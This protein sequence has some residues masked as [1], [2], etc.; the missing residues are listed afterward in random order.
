M[1]NCPARAGTV[2]HPVGS[3]RMVPDPASDAVDARLK[4]YGL[5]W[6]RAVDAAIV[7]TLTS[8]DIN[9]PAI[10][11]AEKAAGRS[12]QMRHLRPYPNVHGALHRCTI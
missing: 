12:W 11:V 10:M 4:F 5:P 2:I 6:L 7:P 1:G 9:A 3:C 8:G